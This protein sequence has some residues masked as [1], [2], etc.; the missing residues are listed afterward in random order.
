[1]NQMYHNW[2]LDLRLFDFLEQVNAKD[3][4]NIEL[5]SK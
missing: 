2:V 5:N 1:M 3:R 4:D